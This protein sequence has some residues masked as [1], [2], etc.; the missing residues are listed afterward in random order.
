L[1]LVSRPVAVFLSL[2]PFRMSLP[3]LTFL[4]WVG[5]KGAVPITLATFPLML[6]TPQASLLF[7]V[8]FFIVV[9]SA[10]V[11]GCSLPLVARWLGLSTPPL[12]S[13]SVTLEISSLRDVDGEVV[14]YTVSEQSH[15]AGRLVRRLALPDGVVIAMVVRS[16][17]IIPPQGKT[18]ILAGDH[19]I[20]VL[21]PGTR[22]LVD[23]IFG[24]KESPGTLP[25]WTE[26]PLRGSITVGEIR[27]LYG[28]A[29]ESDESLT[30]DH[31]LRKR[32]DR[33][34]PATNQTADFGPL[35]FA[36]REVDDDGSIAM[37]G[38]TIQS[39]RP[40]ENPPTVPPTKQPVSGQDANE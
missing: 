10:I 20:I 30:L 19:V 37:V 34:L 39:Q 23:Q 36:I 6:G 33:S 24:A 22:P 9:L 11:Q 8:V 28:V 5:L 32:V 12:A 3:E 38:M 15:A 21:K 40:T 18:E 35:H 31:V 16:H 1:I 25:R 7:D 13:P 2:I 29:I 17:Q 14:D 27:Q 26:F 4:S